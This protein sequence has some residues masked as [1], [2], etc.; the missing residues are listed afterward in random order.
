MTAETFWT[1][2]SLYNKAT[3][4]FQAILIIAALT[5]TYR[6]F[7]KPGALTDI[8]M[9]AF[10]A[11]AFTWN[12]VVF[13]LVFVRNPIATFFGAPVFVVLAILFVLDI[14]AKRTSFQLPDATWK[15]RLTIL[16]VL[17][18]FLYPLIGLPLGH[19]YP[20]MLTPVMPCPLTVFAI[21]IVAASA[22]KV[23][24][25]I[26]ALLLPWALAALPKCFGVLD[27][28]EDCI[29]FASGVYGL[30]ILIR[31]WRTISTGVHST[32]RPA[33]QSNHYAGY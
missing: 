29:L 19:A 7:V 8:W 5:L 4:P 3:W 24:R 14:F 18:V 23:D 33:E 2:V 26:L 12:A 1:Q 16:W 22:P 21:A 30:I 31:E 25:K 6:V 11:T 13:F 15:K 28:Y 32:V 17:L 10:L 20:R 9:K 27:C